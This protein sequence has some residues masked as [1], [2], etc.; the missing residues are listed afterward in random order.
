MLLE[1]YLF[2]NDL[3]HK[4]VLSN[5]ITGGGCARRVHPSRK[6]L[7]LL[8]RSFFGQMLQFNKHL[9]VS[10][11]MAGD[12]FLQ[13]S[14]EGLGIGLS[15]VPQ[16]TGNT[17]LDIFGGMLLPLA[18]PASEFSDV[19]AGQA[20]M[21][22]KDN[23]PQESASHRRRVDRAAVEIEL[24]AIRLQ[25]P[26]DL[27]EPGLQLGFVI[28]EKHKVIDISKIRQTMQHFL[29]KMIQ[30][31]QIVVGKILA[32]QVSDRQA[33]A[34]LQ[35]REQIIAGKVIQHFHLFIAVIDDGINQPQYLRITNTRSDQEFQYFVIDGRKVLFNV[36]FQ[37]KSVLLHVLLETPDC[38]AGAFAHAIGIGVEDETP[39][40][41]R[42]DHIHQRVM[43]D[44]ITKGRSADHT[45]L[46]I[47]NGKGLKAK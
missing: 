21:G 43:H 37:H 23:L 18:Q 24:E 19:L 26:H 2:E 41:N 42:A 9:L 32:C 14:N 20:S 1:Q 5:R 13:C 3:R 15:G 45:R 8:L 10:G 6:G 27:D 40:Q 7:P 29:D 22:G 34:P 35:R 38:L 30:G 17:L 4:T 28:A 11:V 39:L 44:A 33:F 47:L 46:G 31:A 16:P 12:L 25:K 36:T